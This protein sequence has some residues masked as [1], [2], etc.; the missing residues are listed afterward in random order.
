MARV[1][2]EVF[3]DISCPFTHVGLHRIVTQRAERGLTQPLL[4]VRAWPL[5]IVNGAPLNPDLVAQHVDELRE[6]VAPDLFQGFDRGALPNSS[7][8]ALAMVAAAYRAGDAQGERASLAVR[9]A[10]FEEGRNVGDPG[11]LAAIAGDLD[12]ET[13]GP[14]DERSVLAD[15]EEGVR[16]GVLG[17]PEFFLDGH[18][19]F[20][21]ALEISRRGDRL[22]IKPD[23]EGF[24]EFAALCFA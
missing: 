11:V 12:I 19:W 1:F 22:D 18:G 14:D 2:V 9:N 10:L 13:V 3:A 23:A 24:A 21:P 15:Y 20:C 16:R 4:R 17:S 8:P 6:Q 5:E 7:L